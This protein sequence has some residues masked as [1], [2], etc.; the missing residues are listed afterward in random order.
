MSAK[1]PSSF[2]TRKLPQQPSL[3]QLRKQGKDLLLHYRDGNAETA[4]EVAQFGREPITKDAL[5]LTDAY[6]VLARAYGFASWSKLKAFVD[7]ANVAAFAAAVQA[8][9][10]ARVRSLLHGRPELVGMDRSADDEHRA[11]H[12]AVLNRDAAMVRLLM[13]AGPD[14]RKGNFRIATRP[15][16]WRS[17][18]SAHTKTSWP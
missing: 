8:G 10:L 14:A 3:E 1:F 12:Y 4:A 7:G 18:E 16:L 5:T 13:E 17:H 15:P 6:R 9:D 2:P 11:L